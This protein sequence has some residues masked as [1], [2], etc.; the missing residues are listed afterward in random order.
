MPAQPR[1]LTKELMAAAG[2]REQKSGAG[3]AE[4]Y[5]LK[6]SR[7]DYASH[8]AKWFD[9]S[10]MHELLG[11]L[12]RSLPELNRNVFRETNLNTLASVANQLDVTLRVEKLPG[13]GI[14]GFYVNDSAFSA[15]PLI[16]LNDANPPVT[17]AAAFWHEIG[18]HLTQDVFGTGRDRL[19]LTFTSSYQEHLDDSEELLADIVMTLG[20]YPAST[21][22]HLFSL[23]LANSPEGLIKLVSKASCYVRSVSGFEL[24]DGGSMKKKLHM[25]AG[26]I[27]V[28]KLRKALLE[29]YGI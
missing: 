18:H 16:V 9:R 22:K 26:M 4:D 1:C 27:H 15:R 10:Q 24:S 17:V 2:D 19:N 12:R 20:A 7:L 14:R 29:G 23:R 5:F 21:A 13:L 11:D 3:Q 6:I 25:V 28:A 8:I